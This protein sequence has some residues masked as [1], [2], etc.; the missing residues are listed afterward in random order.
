[1]NI[2]MVSPKPAP[3]GARMLTKLFPIQSD[4]KNDEKTVRKIVWPKNGDEIPTERAPAIRAV[5]RRLR[6]IRLRLIPRA[7]EG[8]RHPNSE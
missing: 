3:L 2:P 4:M 8:F 6:Q 5:E 1:M 7:D